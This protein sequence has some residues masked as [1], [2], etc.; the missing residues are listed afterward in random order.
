MSHRFWADE[1]KSQGWPSIVENVPGWK[2]EHEKASSCFAAVQR[3][4]QSNRW[5]YGGAISFF[6]KCKKNILSTSQGCR[7]KKK[8]REIGYQMEKVVWNQI[9]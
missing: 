3:E 5:F 9:M 1:S 2:A 7:R 4:K 6:I 8:E